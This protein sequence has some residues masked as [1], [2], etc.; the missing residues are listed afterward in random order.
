[1][2]RVLNVERVIEVGRQPLTQ[3]ADFLEPFLPGVENAACP[4]VY[5]PRPVVVIADQQI[6]GRT[7]LPQS[8]LKVRRHYHEQIDL[9]RLERRTVEA[10]D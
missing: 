9:L 4:L 2:F 7:S 5:Q 10:R 1:M 6:D 8:R 3:Q